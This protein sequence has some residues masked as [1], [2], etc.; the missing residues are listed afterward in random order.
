[1]MNIVRAE[2]L[3]ADISTEDI[4]SLASELFQKYG[5]VVY[6]NSPSEILVLIKTENK[7]DTGMLVSDLKFHLPLGTCDVSMTSSLSNGVTKVQINIAPAKSQRMSQMFR[8]RTS[9]RENVILVAD[10][11]LYIRS[12]IAKG[13]ADLG[14]VFEVISG[15][16]VTEAYAKHNPDIVFLDYHLPGKNGDALLGELFEIDPDA[17]I[18]MISADSSM[19]NV[20]ETKHKGAKTFLAKPFTKDRLVDCIRTCPTVF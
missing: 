5:G 6:I 12:L 1:M 8:T 14:S 15:T 13:L 9:R 16:E 20:R 4:A 2:K 10:D 3:D 19:D 17:Q 7:S 18:V 11:D